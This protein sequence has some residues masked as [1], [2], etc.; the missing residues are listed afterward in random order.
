MAEFAKDCLSKN[1]NFIGICCGA[2]APPCSR[3]GGC[4]R[5]KTD[6]L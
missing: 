6:I 2:A 5:K 1:I 4:A 3:N